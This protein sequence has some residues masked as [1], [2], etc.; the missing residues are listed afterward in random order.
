MKIE[1]FKRVCGLELFGMFFVVRGRFSELVIL[2]GVWK[3]FKRFFSDF[4]V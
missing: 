4:D 2:F 1:V 3:I